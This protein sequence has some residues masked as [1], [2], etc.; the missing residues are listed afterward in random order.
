M[1]RVLD[2]SPEELD[3][4]RL[5]LRTARQKRLELISRSTEHLMARMD[6]AAG[7]ANTKVL[8]HPTKSRTVVHSSDHV[9]TAVVD[10][11]GRL[12]IERGRQSLEARR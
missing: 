11:Q 1:R 6:A 3:R 12:G 8:V 4:H 10:F 2:A 7:M 5:A 9:A